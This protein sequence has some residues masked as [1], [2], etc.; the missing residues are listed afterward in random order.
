[1]IKCGPFIHMGPDSNSRPIS[2]SLTIDKLQSSLI[3]FVRKMGK[4]MVTT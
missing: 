1:M 2:S 3:C 4:I